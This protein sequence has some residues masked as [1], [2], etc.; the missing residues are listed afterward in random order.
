MLYIL[1]IYLFTLFE[2]LDPTL[3]VIIYKVMV[4]I[5]FIL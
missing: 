2:K 3:S 5:V 4:H 1:V